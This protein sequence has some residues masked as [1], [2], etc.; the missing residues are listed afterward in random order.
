MPDLSELLICCLT[1]YKFTQYVRQ[2]TTDLSIIKHVL[3]EE[4]KRLNELAQNY[5][6]KLDSLPKGSLSKKKRNMS[7]YLYW[8]FRDNN[9]VRFIYIG[10]EDSKVAKK[11]LADRKERIRYQEMLKKVKSDIQ[12]I[13]RAFN[14]Y[15]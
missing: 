4:F 6:V 15:K 5:K 9:K 12:E 1:F 14:G 7:F 10:P 3:D 2:R 11:A 8:A 13:K